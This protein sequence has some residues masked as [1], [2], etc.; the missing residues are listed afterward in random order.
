[1]NERMPSFL[2]KYEHFE[3]QYL[4]ADFSPR[5]YFRWHHEKTSLILMD[6]PDLD[7]LNAFVSVDRYLRSIG[8]NAPEIYEIDQQL[9]L[10]YCK[11]AQDESMKFINQLFA[12]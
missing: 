11:K 6:S 4:T 1:M 10:G 3:K 2:Q 5:K 8:L 12:Y 7:S 9:L